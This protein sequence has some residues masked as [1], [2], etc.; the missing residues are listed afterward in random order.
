MKTLQT[1]AI[2][3]IAGLLLASCGS[4]PE[5]QLEKLKAQK[6]KINQQIAQLETQSVQEGSIASPARLTPVKLEASR[7]NEFKHFVEV[8][9]NVESESNINVPAESP[10]IVQRIY[11]TRG[12]AVKRGQLLAELDATIIQK[13]I[14]QVETGLELATTMFERQQRLWDQK[15]GS[16]MQFLQAKANKESLEKQL[17]TLNEQLNL[18][19][20]TSPINGT[21]DEIIIK[22]GEMAAP[23][24]PAFRIVELSNLK[25]K[26]N[27]SES[28]INSVKPGDPVSVRFPLLNRELQLKVN[29]VT[30]VIDP[31]SRTFSVEVRIPISES[32]IKPNMIAV[33]VVN[34]YVNHEAISVPLN[35]VQKNGQGEFLFVAEHKDKQMIAQRRNVKTGLTYANRVEVLEGIKAGENIIVFG[36]QNLADGQLITADNL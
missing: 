35:S 23:G 6:E 10:G 33:L 30:Q 13:S 9:G 28:Y 12:S 11:V 1:S 25:V 2:I 18:F 21:V 14:S 26:A 5:A 36:H 19:R 22:E 34:N 29:A 3:L 24:F 7:N 15:I 4:N 31:N 32:G 27:L 8:Q 20:I 16:E 17:A